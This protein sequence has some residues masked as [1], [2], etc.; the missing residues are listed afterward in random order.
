MILR[1]LWGLWMW[2]A[3]SL[4]GLLARGNATPA[5]LTLSGLIIS[6]ACGVLLAIGEHPILPAAGG[7]LL[8]AG[9]CDA[10]DGAVAR[11]RKWR[12]PFGAI[13]DSVADRIADGLVL[14]GLLF[15]VASN[16]ALPHDFQQGLRTILCLLALATSVLVPYVRAR[17]EGIVPSCRVGLWVR[18]VRISVLAAGFLAGHRFS[19]VLVLA[20][21]PWA[22]VIRRLHHA[23]ESIRAGI[24]LANGFSVETPA[25]SGREMPGRFGPLHDL[26]I[27]GALALA[28]FD[29]FGIG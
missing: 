14:A 25:D 24:M 9:F 20:V 17:A 10:L 2:L 15:W 16:P 29:P 8:A 6:A 23:R 5:I 1:R 22:T 4:A 11:A 3:E 12:W 19:G 21:L 28:I 7:L 18:G 27:A 26:V 13:V